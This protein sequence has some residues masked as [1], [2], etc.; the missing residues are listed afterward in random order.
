[1]N[2]RII[3]SNVDSKPDETGRKIT[4]IKR[5]N[6]DGVCSE[7]SVNLYRY[8]TNITETGRFSVFWRNSQEFFP[9]FQIRQ[10]RMS[11]VVS[12]DKNRDFGLC[13][14]NLTRN[15]KFQVETRRIICIWSE[16][17]PIIMSHV[18]NNSP[19]HLNRSTNPKYRRGHSLCIVS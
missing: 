4:M 18:K 15:I 16:T 8:F 10:V 19:I 17:F 14:R 11:K 1:M 7:S 9:R 2:T 3:A 6:E 13:Y 5:H 12:L